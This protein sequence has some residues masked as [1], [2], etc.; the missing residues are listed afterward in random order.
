V[1]GNIGD[2]FGVRRPFEVSLA[3]QGSL[4]IYNFFFTPYID[5]KTLSDGKSQPKGTG[6]LF[7][8]L[9]VLVPQR[10]R[11]ASGKMTK[12]WGVLCL[13]IGIFIGCLATGFTPI[14]IQL[15]ATDNFRFDQTANGYLLAGN[16]LIRGIFLVWIFPVIISAGRKWFGPGQSK[17]NPAEGPTLEDDAV[18]PDIQEPMPT[19]ASPPAA[20]HVTKPD[21]EYFDLFFLRW[22]LVMDAIVTAGIALATT[23]WHLYLAAFALPL[24]TGSAPAARGVITQMLPSSK[25]VDALQTIT[26]IEQI[27]H[28]ATVGVCGFVFAVFT[29]I[30]KAYLTFYL[31]AVGSLCDQISQQTR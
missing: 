26:I 3:I 15:Y 25:R 17:S 31:N 23:G 7:G 29:S 4:L 28:L 18:E 24:S 21:Y 1:G 6:A 12:H 10:L 14:L 16:S 5:P 20:A 30:G 22:S 2:A 19:T 8:Q 9:G 11:L 27:G 13:G